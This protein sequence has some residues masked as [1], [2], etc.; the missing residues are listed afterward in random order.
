MAEA[1]QQFRRVNGHLHLPALRDALNRHHNG[2]RHPAS[3][4]SG[5]S[6]KSAVQLSVPGGI[7]LGTL[8]TSPS[9]VPGSTRLIRISAQRGPFCG[10]RRKT[11]NARRTVTG[12]HAERGPRPCVHRHPRI[13]T[14]E[15]GASTA[16]SARPHLACRDQRYP[17]PVPDP[18]L[19][20]M[21]CWTWRR[22]A[23]CTTRCRN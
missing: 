17:L 23:R 7:Y 15:T 10:R 20:R 11:E 3:T 5:T 19:A 12:E 13:V 18:G 21:R 14:D 1:G 8:G 16:P 4:R 6:S 22:C 9:S 2:A